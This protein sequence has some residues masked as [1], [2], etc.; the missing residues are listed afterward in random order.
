MKRYQHRRSGRVIRVE[1]GTRHHAQIEAHRAWDPV[2]QPE[3]ETESESSTEEK[4][5]PAA[6]EEAP[7]TA[8]STEPES[9]SYVEHAGGPWF[10]VV[11]DGREA[12]KVQGRD[13]ADARLAELTNG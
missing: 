1:P 12:D 10:R 13:A 11:V 9:E 8:V 3:P 2:D 5:S 4:S 6:L 7:A